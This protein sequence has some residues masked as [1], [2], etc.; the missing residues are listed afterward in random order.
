MQSAR[1]LFEHELQSVYDGIKRLQRGLER[2]RK[3]AGNSELS[4][5][6]Q[7]LQTAIGEQIRRLEDIFHLLGKK[8]Q[9]SESKA[10]QGF[11]DEFSDA[12]KQEKPEK[13]ALDVLAGDVTGHI[14]S[15]L[16]ED[17]ETMLL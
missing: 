6:F 8:P 12:L 15:Y 4:S 13:E 16:M 3:R 11:L 17:Y 1:D 2:I 7:E 5:T 14:A 10:I 9:R